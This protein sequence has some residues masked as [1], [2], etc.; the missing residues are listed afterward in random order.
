MSSTGTGPWSVTPLSGSIAPGKYYLV[1]EASGAGNGVD[2]PPSDASGSIAMAAAAG[3]VALLNVITASVGACP[4]FA[5]TADVV[6]YGAAN[7]DEGA[8]PAPATSNTTAALR[9]RGGCFDSNNNNIDF[10]I[11]SPLPRNSA[12]PA[13]SCTF[14]SVAIHEI[15]GDADVTPYLGQDVQTIGIVTARKNNGFFIQTSGDEDSNP[16]TSQGLFVFTQTAPGVAVGDAVTARGTATEF[17]TLTQLESS[18]PGDITVDSTGNAVPAAITLTT[19]ILDADGA[20]NQLERFEGMRLHADVLISVAPTNEFG[21]ILTVLP[22]VARPVREPGIERSQ[23]IPPDPTSGVVDCCIPLWDENPERIMIDSDG[24]IGASRLNV[25]SHVTLAGVTGPLDFTFGDYKVLPDTPPSTSANISAE[26]VRLPLAEEL[27]IGGFNIENFANNATQRRK[28]ALAIRQVMHSPDVIGH[29][30]IASLEALQALATQVNDDAAVDGEFPAYEARLIPAPQGGTQ[31][32]GFLVK[33]SRVQ[34]VSATQE[35]AG[36]TFLDPVHGDI[37]QLHDRPPLVLRANAL[38]PGRGPRPFIVV[39]NHL[40]SFI[41]VGLV[42]GEGIRVRAKRTAQAEATAQLLQTLQTDNP[43]VPVVSIGDYNA[44]QFNDGYTDPIAILKG[45]PT[46]DDE[47]VVDESPDYV[48][49]NFINLTDTLP[50]SEQYSFIFAGTPQALDHMLLNTVASSLVSGYE[51]A[52]NN[53]DFPEGPLFANDVTRPERNSDHDMPVAYLSFPLTS[54]LAVSITGPA[55]PIVTGATFSYT[56][57]AAND[58]PDAAAGVTV[59]IP[60]AAGLRFNAIVIAAGWSCTTPSPGA[61]G[62]I[63]CTGSLG[64]GEN[65]SFLV[66]AILDCGVADATLIEQGVAIAGTALDPDGANDSAAASIVASNPP[67]SIAGV[68]TP[69]VVSPTSA[70]GAVVSNAQL[71]S[72]IAV[73]TCGGASIVRTGVPAGNVFPVGTTIVTYTATDSGGATAVATQTV[74]V[75]SATESLQTIVSDLQAIIDGSTT[76]PLTAR[77]T[78]ARKKVEEA[79]AYLAETPPDTLQAAIRIR[80]AMQDIEGLMNQGLLPAAIANSL[81]QRLAGVSSMI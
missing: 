18:L 51:I 36:Q 59:M 71:G 55:A 60:A 62:A 77:A 73:D 33:T 31:H 43:G 23:P 56:V 21:E 66:S 57:N 26:P 15:Q 3:K 9:K 17:F 16:E 34:I 53:S 58:G 75:L 28:A 49:P 65:V 6:G 20:D 67:P 81:L 2:L 13:R 4:T 72:P 24:V 69:I 14:T 68:I 41:E 50:A 8:G 22:G 35:L 76:A 11:G 52:R 5:A 47:I 44:Y 10:S 54:D 45:T 78:D 40:R 64:S 27:T 63:S 70:S 46:S 30:E 80:Q 38:L 12:T 7:C 39:V 32:V 25:T 61:A 19:S 42:D 79:I 74:K 48:E 1:H 37:E 29:V